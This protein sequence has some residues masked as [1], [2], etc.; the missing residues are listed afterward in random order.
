MVVHQV[1]RRV[2]TPRPYQPIVTNHILEVPR[3]AVWADMGLG[4]T[5]S[6]LT[7]LD[8]LFMVE[9][10]PALVIAP[11]RVARSTWSEEAARWEHLRD[12]VVSPIVG[13]E[14]ERRAALK[15]D[16]NVYTTN[17]D[18]LPWLIDTLGDKWP[19]DKVVADESTKL[20]SYRGS[21]QTSKAGKTFVRGGGGQ[22]ARALGS[23][24]HTKIK[25]FIELTGT[26]APR[27]LDCLWAQAWYLDAGQRL[28][29]TFESFMNRW[30]TKDFD[31]YTIKPLPY[32][33][34]EIEDRLRDLCISIDPKDYFDLRE[35]IINNIYVDMP[36]KARQLYREMEKKMF[37]EIAGHEVEAFNAAAKTM[38]CLQLA[39]GAAYVDDA[40]AWEE[41]HT[42]K[43]EALE[44]IVEEASGSPVIAV[45]HF[46][47]DLA[48]LKR[49][50]PKALVLAN[51]SE[52]EEFKRGS[53][54]LGLAHEQSLGHGIDGLQNVCHRMAF[55]AHGWNLETY[56][57]IIGR[58]GPVRQMQAGF[59][60]PVYLHNILARD[61]VDELVMAR[62]ETK[63]SVQNILLEAM[64]RKAA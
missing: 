18:V 9:P 25:R 23:I 64:K 37:A 29:R 62:R 20:K 41:T 16:A 17:Y 51:D 38:K 52:L 1:T 11:L 6:V 49:A 60:R 42:A 53:A 28:G 50:F 8:A 2:Y 4:K 36:S 45:Y 21:M 43:I 24:A 10:R 12:I 32:A 7:A 61:T 58:I 3:C 54:A 59:E 56:M 47:S 33:Q 44:D 46:K 26:P 27:G 30:F 57:Q 31:G 55:F 15:R 13:N 5:C 48:R 19:F 40:G 14:A 34:T 22:R 39:N 63:R 35:P